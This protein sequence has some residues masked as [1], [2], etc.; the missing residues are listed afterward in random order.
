MPGLLSRLS[1]RPG[2]GRGWQH[3]AHTGPD[4]ALPR[5]ALGVDGARYCPSHKMP[6]P[7]TAIGLNGHQSLT[8]DHHT[9]KE[10]VVLRCERQ[11]TEFGLLFHDQRERWLP[12]CIRQVLRIDTL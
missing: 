12:W 2:L 9:I 1:L 8:T 5:V 11:H 7:L 6:R 3:I 4:L 10:A